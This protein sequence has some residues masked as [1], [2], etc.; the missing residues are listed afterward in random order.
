MR[1]CMKESVMKNHASGNLHN[2]LKM[3]IF[4]VALTK[5]LYYIN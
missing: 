4:A 5:Q 3:A 1:Q 2:M